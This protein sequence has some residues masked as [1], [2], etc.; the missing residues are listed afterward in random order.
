MAKIDGKWTRIL[1]LDA[2]PVSGVFDE[3]GDETE[4]LIT[5]PYRI[6]EMRFRGIE[7]DDEAT[8]RTQFVSTDAGVFERVLPPEQDGDIW[9]NEQSVRPF[10]FSNW[11][12][13]DVI[14]QLLDKM[15]IVK[16]RPTR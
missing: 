2:I 1:T 9:P 3:R 14:F 10:K 16:L 6:L 12:G 13:S 15:D 11:V 5:G 8:P 7:V 4:R